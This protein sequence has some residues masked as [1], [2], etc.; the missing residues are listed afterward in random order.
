[1]DGFNFEIRNKGVFFFQNEM[2]YRSAKMF[3]EIYMLNL[4]SL[5]LNIES[6]RLKSNNFKDSYLWHY[7]LGDINDKH[8]TRLHKDGYLGSFDR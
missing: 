5:N 6:K 7:H 3:S 2:F 1:M 8:L 4:Y